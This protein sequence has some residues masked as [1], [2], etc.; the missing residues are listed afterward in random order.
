MNSQT[1]QQYRPI[2]LAS[3]TP[4]RAGQT[5]LRGILRH[6][7]YC[8]GDKIFRNWFTLKERCPNCNTLFAHEDGYFLGS[9]VINLVLTSFIAMGVVLWMLIASDFSVLQMQIA[10]VLLAV[11]LPLFLFPYSLSFW[12]TLDLVIHTDF[13]NRPRV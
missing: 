13:S 2:D 5:L 1:N 10:G 4:K 6:C 7:P 11:G 3:S 9:Y 12:M 8:G